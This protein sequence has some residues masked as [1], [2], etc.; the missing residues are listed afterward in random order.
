MRRKARFSLS[1]VGERQWH[2]RYGILLGALVPF[3]RRFTLRRLEPVC[4]CVDSLSW[5]FFEYLAGGG[6]FLLL[7]PKRFLRKNFLSAAL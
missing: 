3:R 4:R 5:P 7:F 2:V 6:A 1:S